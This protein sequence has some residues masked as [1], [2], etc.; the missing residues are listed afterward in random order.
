MALL[1]QENL[2]KR[3]LS[4]SEIRAFHFELLATFR[5][6]YNGLNTKQI[7]KIR[8]TLN[9]IGEFRKSIESIKN[10]SNGK[11]LFDRF[12]VEAGVLCAVVD[13]EKMSHNEKQIESLQ[14]YLEKN[15][16]DINLSLSAVADHLNLTEAYISNFFKEQTGINYSSYIENLRISRAKELLGGTHSIAD[17]AVQSGYGSKNTFYKAFKRVEGISTGAYRDNLR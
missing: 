15:Y 5:R 1:R 3:P 7:E 13:R 10:A 9:G 11:V 17:V 8:E 14:L 12:T 16:R 4:R 6:T 2:E